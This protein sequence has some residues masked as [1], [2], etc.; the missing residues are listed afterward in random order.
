VTLTAI[1]DIVAERSS[2]SELAWSAGRP[3]PC[4]RRSSFVE[5][6]RRS[7]GLSAAR[8]ATPAVRTAPGRSRTPPADCDVAVP[9]PPS[10]P[11]SPVKSERE[12]SSRLHRV[13]EQRAVSSG[14]VRYWS[15][16]S[17]NIR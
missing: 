8:R 16:T 7:L 17:L 4:R 2:A 13:G 6:L 3:D 12:Q 10:S 14:H 1:V 11:S 5:S 9:S 15:F